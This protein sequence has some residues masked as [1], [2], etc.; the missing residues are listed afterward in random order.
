M[1]RDR[2]RAFFLPCAVLTCDPRF[3]SCSPPS[4]SPSPSLSLFIS[5]CTRFRSASFE[6]SFFTRRFP[7]F[8]ASNE[9]IERRGRRTDRIGMVM[10]NPCPKNANPKIIRY[11]NIF[12]RFFPKRK[13][14]T[15]FSS[16]SLS[17]RT[18]YTHALAFDSSEDERREEG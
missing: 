16:L 17:P 1:I 5:R 6:R 18:R 2:G 14:T 3:P 13:V 15:L 7:P 4:L 11:M 12:Y 10:R 8:R 9:G